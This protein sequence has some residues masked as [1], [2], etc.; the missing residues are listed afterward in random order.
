MA[1]LDVQLVGAGWLQSPSLD[2]FGCAITTPAFGWERQF[3][4]VCIMRS[5]SVTK[6]IFSIKKL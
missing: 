2:I 5:R 3:N 6:S 1:S 4:R